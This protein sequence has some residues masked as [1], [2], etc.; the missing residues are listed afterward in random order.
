[1]NRFGVKKEKKEK[2]PILGIGVCLVSA[3]ILFG[4]VS[5][6]NSKDITESKSSLEKAISNDIALCYSTY[7]F[8]PPDVEF[9]ENHFGLVYNHETYIVDYEYEGSN[10]MPDF[11]IIER[12]RK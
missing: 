9:M 11:M 3:V 5:M 2:I 7:G 12:K 6:L 1:M 4:T 8:Y 10:L